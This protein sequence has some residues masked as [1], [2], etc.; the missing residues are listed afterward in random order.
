MGGVILDLF[1]E[2]VCLSREGKGRPAHVWTL[3]NS[4][5]ISLLFACGHDVKVAAAAIGV[6]VPTLYKHYFNE[7]E[8][9]RHAAIKL[10]A[11]QLERLNREAAKGNVAAEKALAGMVQ[12]ERV[13]V[14]NAAVKSR[15][16]EPKAVA[17]GKKEAAKAAASQ[18]QGRFARRTPP[19]QATLLN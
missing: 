3:E 19:P 4:N 1:G 7:C 2:A 5:R 11:V 6:S 12:A 10:R 18:A 17:M 16:A 8:K 15:P 13:A 14:T 9:R